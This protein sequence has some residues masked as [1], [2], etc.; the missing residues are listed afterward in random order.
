MV[1]EW[2]SAH[3]ACGQG[4]DS[5]PRQEWSGEHDTV[6]Q[7]EPRGPEAEGTFPRSAQEPARLQ[8]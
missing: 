6:Y 4:L 7:E 8:T 1:R 5:L 2:I 3:Q